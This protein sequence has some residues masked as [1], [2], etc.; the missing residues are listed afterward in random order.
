MVDLGRPYWHA[1]EKVA[2]AFPDRN[3]VVNSLGLEV[4]DVEVNCYFNLPRDTRL[5]LGNFLDSVPFVFIAPRS[6]FRALG[7]RLYTDGQAAHIRIGNNEWWTTYYIPTSNQF[8]NRVRVSIN[9]RRTEHIDALVE[10]LR[11][12]LT[13]A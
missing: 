9:L 1:K 13:A 5:T 3:V 12:V 6:V 7:W 2:E 4:D 11:A 10:H 8:A